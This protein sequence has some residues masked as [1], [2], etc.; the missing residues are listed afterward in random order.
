MCRSTAKLLCGVG[1][2]CCRRLLEIVLLRGLAN[3]G[4]F[5]LFAD[6]AEELDG[7]GSRGAEPVW[8]AGVELGD[9]SGFEDEVVF[10]EDEATA[11][12]IILSRRFR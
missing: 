5:A 3:V 6:E 9:F 12:D 1:S 11:A 2:R 7:S 8:G 4:L 10:A